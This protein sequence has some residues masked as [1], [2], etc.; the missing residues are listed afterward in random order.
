MALI[1]QVFLGWDFLT[2]QET[3]CHSL[4]FSLNVNVSITK[5][6]DNTVRLADF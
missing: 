5:N 4:M 6:K 2:E 3:P 1:S